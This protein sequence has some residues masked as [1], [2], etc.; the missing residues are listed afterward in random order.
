VRVTA[1]QVVIQPEFSDGLRVAVHH[2][3]NAATIDHF[4]GKDLMQLQLIGARLL[5][6]AML[7]AIYREHAEQIVA[8][9][10]RGEL[11]PD[12]LPPTILPMIPIFADAEGNHFTIV[13]NEQGLVAVPV[14]AGDPLNPLEQDT[15]SGGFI[16]L[17]TLQQANAKPRDDS[18]LHPEELQLAALNVL[19]D[20]G[21]L[22]FPFTGSK[23]PFGPAGRPDPDPDRDHLEKLPPEEQEGDRK[24]PP[25]PGEPPL[26]GHAEEENPGSDGASM[27]DGLPRQLAESLGHML[28][29]EAAKAMATEG[30]GSALGSSLGNLQGLGQGLAVAAGGQL[31]GMATQ[32]LMS[33]LW[34]VDDTASAGEQAAHHLTN[35]FVSQVQGELY[36]QALGTAGGSPMARLQ[37][38]FSSTPAGGF[39][40]LRMG[41]LD[42]SANA[43]VA[44][45]P[46]VLVEGAPAAHINHPTLPS[47]VMVYRGSASVLTNGLF[48]SR[49]VLSLSQ[50][51]WFVTGASTVYV[52]GPQAGAPPP[53]PESGD[54]N[55]APE[56]PA[57][58][59]PVELDPEVDEAQPEF[60][61]E[62]ADD[63]SE[64]LDSTV[65]EP[66]EELDEIVTDPREVD[67]SNRDENEL[68]EPTEPQ[69]G[70]NMTP[71]EAE[72]REQLLEELMSYI[73]E[74]ELG[75]VQNPSE[76]QPDDYP[77]TPNDTEGQQSDEQRRREE[78]ENFTETAG[79]VEDAA[80]GSASQTAEVLERPV[81]DAQRAGTS[82]RHELAA[83]RAPQS[84]W[85]RSLRRIPLVGRFI[86]GMSFA[87]DPTFVNAVTIGT[88][89]YAA[90][91]G[92]AGGAAAGF[93]FCGPYCAV[94]GAAIGGVA[95]GYGGEAAVNSVTGV[96][97]NVPEGPAAF[98]PEWWMEIVPPN[99]VPIA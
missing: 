61:S 47:G 4:N 49:S 64:E 33:S 76:S 41:D 39:P 85:A 59:V 67:S 95:G 87:A 32:Q 65:S 99:D 5:P 22:P 34:S 75:D 53:P 30:L 27:L 15:S 19:R 21:Q 36:S 63:I 45:S 91:K 84:R 81:K 8:A 35:R 38:F 51:G 25:L 40:A 72:L 74:D 69:V 70:D 31:A 55:A 83:R 42:A 96:L 17:E 14:E 58:P 98:T 28:V 86:D 3:V 43:V 9:S 94:G 2:R 16:P 89:A 90:G 68:P 44:G 11:D 6:A 80:S 66:L 10:E 54:G 12:T 71:E 52:G 29:G 57:A 50:D 88:S 73:Q 13:P 37:N 1:Q 92:A 23:S 79:R 7:D 82:N 62:T 93:W 46:N 48:Q 60:D 97:G 56:A 77:T 78:L 24:K 18:M 26:D 20:S